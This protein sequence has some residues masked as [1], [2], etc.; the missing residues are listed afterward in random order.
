MRR[1][2]EFI[3]EANRPCRDMAALMSAALDEELDWPQR[4]AY[5]L[6]LLYCSACRRYRRQLHALQ[7]ALRSVSDA[8]HVP[9]AG[10]GPQMPAATRER[11][12]HVLRER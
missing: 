10:V 12:M 9:Q 1:I 2:I 8:L 6:H 4:W 11:I 5:R 3:R 7:R